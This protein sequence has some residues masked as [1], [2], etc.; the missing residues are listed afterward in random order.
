MC[1]FLMILMGLLYMLIADQLTTLELAERLGGDV[2]VVAQGWEMISPLW[3]LLAF[4]FLAGV[5]TVLLV[6]KLVPAQ[7]SESHEKD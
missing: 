1:I 4:T 5:L 7:K 3:G 2:I 6:M